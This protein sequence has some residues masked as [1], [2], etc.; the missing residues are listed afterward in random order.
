M[1]MSTLEVGQKTF[2]DMSGLQQLLD[3]LKKRGYR[4]MGPT[5]RDHAIVY[6]ELSSVTDLPMGWTGEQDE[7]RYGLK[8]RG[9]QAHFGY[10]V[11]PHSWK[12]FLCAPR[13]LLWRAKRID[14]SRR[15]RG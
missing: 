8:R 1:T 6:N 9:D 4:V 10:A 11:G 3:T 15:L 7:G 13:S 2:I 5:L 14:L 12:Q